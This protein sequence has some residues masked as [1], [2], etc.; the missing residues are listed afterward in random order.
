MSK[1]RSLSSKLQK[2]QVSMPTMLERTLAHRMQSRENKRSFQV[3][4]LRWRPRSCRQIMPSPKEIHAD[5]TRKRNTNQHDFTRI[6]SA[7]ITF[8]PNSTQLDTRKY[9]SQSITLSNSSMKS[10]ETLKL[11]S[12]T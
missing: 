8:G 9:R 3:W 12:Q 6:L 1:T 2:P 5:K 4:K 10:S 7:G 11:S